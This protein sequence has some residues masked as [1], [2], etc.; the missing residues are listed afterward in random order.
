M[1]CKHAEHVHICLEI[2]P[3]LLFKYYFKPIKFRLVVNAQCHGFNDHM[4]SSAHKDLQILFYDALPL[5]LI[6]PLPTVSKAGQPL[7]R[8][9]L[10][11]AASHSIA[12]RRFPNGLEWKRLNWNWE[13]I[14]AIRG[15]EPAIISTF[16]I[17]EHKCKIVASGIPPDSQV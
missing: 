12:N 13:K 11:K 5:N 8:L 4:W 1:G 10:L 16:I 9:Q 2:F 3:C 14:L 15:F 17:N 7:N 6:V